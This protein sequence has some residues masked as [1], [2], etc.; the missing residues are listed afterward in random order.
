MDYNI[1]SELIEEF[2]AL[3]ERPGKRE[4]KTYF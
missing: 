3:N 2:F 1:D 4:S